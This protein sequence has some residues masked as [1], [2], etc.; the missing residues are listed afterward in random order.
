ML[1]RKD[2]E[3]TELSLSTFQ[4]FNEEIS[5]DD[6]IPPDRSLTISGKALSLNSIQSSDAP[7]QINHNFSHDAD[8]RMMSS[9]Q[10]SVISKSEDKRENTFQVEK[11]TFLIRFRF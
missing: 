5:F 7:A 11:R 10:V 9:V 3:R 2:Q 1:N 4:E 6:T 8:A